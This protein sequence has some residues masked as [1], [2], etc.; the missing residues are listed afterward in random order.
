M[1][2]GS[3][4][5]LAWILFCTPRARLLCQESC[6]LTVESSLLVDISLGPVGPKVTF[7][8]D[9]QTLGVAEGLW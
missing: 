5:R 8:D 4:W 9:S 2:V 6:L 1:T 3:R 7:D